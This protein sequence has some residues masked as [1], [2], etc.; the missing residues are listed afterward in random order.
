VCNEPLS[1]LTRAALISKLV[2]GVVYHKGRGIGRF[3]PSQLETTYACRITI[4]SATAN[5][6]QALLVRKSLVPAV[7]YLEVLSQRRV[8]YSATTRRGGGRRREQL[9]RHARHAPRVLF[10]VHSSSGFQVRWAMRG[11]TTV[12]GRGTQYYTL[13]IAWGQGQVLKG[14]QELLNEANTERRV[15]N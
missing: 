12:S 3:A 4:N 1:A 10:A 13:S 15:G 6:Q 7:P 9:S 2:G 8:D 14:L 11:M 5:S